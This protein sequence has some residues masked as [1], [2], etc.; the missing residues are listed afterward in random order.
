MAKISEALYYASWF[1]QCKF[2]GKRKPLQSVVFLTDRCNLACKHCSIVRTG[3]DCH[4]KT[5]EQIR[6]DLQ[7]CYDSGSRIVDLQGGEPHLW[8]DSSDEARAQTPD[9]E[10][11]TLNTVVDL[12]R[13]IGFFSVSVTTNAQ[14]PITVTSDLVWTSLDGMEERHDEQRGKGAFARSLKHIAECDHPNLNVNMCITKNNYQ[15]F[16]D[17]VELVKDHPNLKKFAFSFYVPLDGNRDLLVDPAIRSDI[18]DKALRFK[19]AGYPMM[20]SA[21]GI[22]L[23]RDP[24]L[25]VPKRQCWISNFIL[26][27]G[28]RLDRC[29]GEAAGAC[30]DCGFGMCAEMTLLWNLNPEMVKAGLSV[31]SAKE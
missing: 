7:Y 24:K 5:L 22:A 14:M 23:L 9:G 17:V 26:S 20:N 10:P 31:R 15:D 16:E 12:A 6:D 4:N 8:K 13:T 18:I 29:Q 30:D 21:A 19:A 3:P 28:T 11:A 1:A 2:L 27:D 25:F